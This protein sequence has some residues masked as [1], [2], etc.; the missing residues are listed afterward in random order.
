VLVLLRANITTIHLFLSAKRKRN[1]SHTWQAI[2]KG[3]QV[4]EKGLIKLIGDGTSTQAWTDQWIP[5]IPGFKP[6]YKKP[7]ATVER[8]HELLTS[9]GSAWNEQVL[10]ENFLEA[11]AKE[12]RKIPLGRLKEDMLAWSAEKIAYTLSNL[13]ID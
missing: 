5:E 3:R 9:E 2:L 7:E 12:I 13:H 6:L 11:D 8:V 4:L 1:S 10:Q